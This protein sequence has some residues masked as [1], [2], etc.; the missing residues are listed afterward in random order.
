MISEVTW[1]SHGD[2]LSQIRQSVF[3]EEQG[4]SPEDEWDIMDLQARH[5]LAFNPQ[6]KPVGCARI[7]ETQKIGRMAVLKT[8]RG[9]RVGSKLLKVAIQSIPKSIGFAKLGAQL[10]AIPLYALHGFDTFGHLFI[11]AGIPHRRMRLNLNQSTQF[12]V[13]EKNSN[14]L[15]LKIN[16]DREEMT[17]SIS[18]RILK[19]RLSVT[20]PTNI[21][22]SNNYDNCI[23]S[24]ISRQ[25]S[26]I[27]SGLNCQVLTIKSEN[28]CKTFTVNPREII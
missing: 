4:I 3:V 13:G 1:S 2:I 16:N 15:I 7:S 5:F 14:C 6:G 25:L 27:A 9:Q 24:L 20:M 19:N 18:L 11:D 23:P 10:H 17:D 26:L 28:Y 22:E 21:F 12:S 8:E